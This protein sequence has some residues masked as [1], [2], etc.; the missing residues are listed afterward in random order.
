[1]NKIIHKNNRGFKWFS[2]GGCYVKGYLFGTDG[3]LYEKEEMHSYFQKAISFQD[4]GDKVKNANGCFSVI[5]ESDDILWIATDII[6]S[7]PLFYMKSETGWV[8][9]DEAYEL[10]KHIKAPSV[11]EITCKEFKGTGYVTSHETLIEGVMQVQAGEIVQLSNEVSR[12]FYFSYR[13]KESSK[14]LYEK[15]RSEG[16]GIFERTFGRIIQSLNGRTAVVPL[17]GGFDSRL[18]AVMLKKAGYEKVV[19][20]TYGRKGNQEAAISKNVAEQLDFSWYFVEYTPELI[21]DFIGSEEFQAY[22]PFASNFTSMFFMQEYFAVH[23]LKKHDLIPGDSVFIPGHS[24]DFLGGSQFAKHGY[25]A[26]EESME[27]LVKRIRN[28][29]YH[30]ENY[31]GYDGKLINRRIKN[32]IEEK[33][34]GFDA[35]AY[36]IHEDYDLKEKLAKF[37]ANCIKTYTFFGFEF[38]LLYWDIELVRFFSLVPVSAKLNKILYDDILASNYFNPF[39]LNFHN[40]LHTDE[41][42]YSRGRIKKKIKRLLPLFIINFFTKKEDV[43]C[44]FEITSKLN[45]DLSSRG[46]RPGSFGNS[47]NK[48]IIEWYLNTLKDELS[49]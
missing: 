15:L 45:N 47:Y 26:S 31:G 35:L 2:G 20:Y 21:K 33:E 16:I 41:K 11:N 40:E 30:Y 46:I 8:V 18:I 38:R 13:V 22:Y 12:K 36:S 4:F 1:M 5:I 48:V 43:L 23:Y 29:K 9:S 34:S 10:K 25:S 42:E 27:T 19:C 49:G 6:R 3:K 14:E 44:Y 17:S 24:G 37:N 7:L 28:V 39:G 32:A